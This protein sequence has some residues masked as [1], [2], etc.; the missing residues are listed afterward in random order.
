MLQNMLIERFH[1]V[2]H[3]EKRDFP[4]YELVVDTGGPKFKEVTPAQDPVDDAKIDMAAMMNAGRDAD[5]FFKLPPG[6][7]IL[8]MGGKGISRTKYQEQTMATFV[9]NLGNLIGATQGK[10]VLD[11]HLQPRVVDKTG[12]TGKYTFILEYS[13]I[14]LS[15]V[16]SRVAAA[17]PSSPLGNSSEPDDPAGGAPNIIDAVQKQLGL[18]LDKVAAVPLDVIVIDSLDKTPTEN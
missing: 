18:R 11:G 15:I 2:Y 9:S 4:G 10:S 12:L 13:D 8:T 14:G 7:R 6:P 5:G 16:R 17:F 3:R 1:L